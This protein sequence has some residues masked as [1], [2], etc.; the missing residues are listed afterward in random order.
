[1][2][3]APIRYKNEEHARFHT[4]PGPSCH[5]DPLPDLRAGLAPDS[6]TIEA[7]QKTIVDSNDDFE[8]RES[9]NQGECSS[10]QPVSSCPDA[11]RAVRN[12]REIAG[13]TS[14]PLTKKPTGENDD[15]NASPL[16]Q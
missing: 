4:S 14:H 5:L 7:S 16:L 2:G 13:M 9:P 10:A 3:I 6:I 15:F 1:M 11:V 12:T 8:A